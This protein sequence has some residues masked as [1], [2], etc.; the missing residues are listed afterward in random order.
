MG[1]SFVKD[2]FRLIGIVFL[3]IALPT[4]I[5]IVIIYFANIFRVQLTMGLSQIISIGIVLAAIFSRLDFFLRIEYRKIVFE[6]GDLLYS[7]VGLLLAVLVTTIAWPVASNGFSFLSLRI[8]I[9]Q[10]IMLNL[11]TR[12]PF[13]TYKLLLVIKIKDEDRKEA[14]E[15]RQRELERR[16]KEEYERNIEERERKIAEREKIERQERRKREQGENTSPDNVTPIRRKS[17]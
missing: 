12:I 16:K 6:R 3:Y 4:S 1:K 14:E 7:A 5:G 15:T 8:N 17:L 10:A 11:G 9:L 2:L 13:L